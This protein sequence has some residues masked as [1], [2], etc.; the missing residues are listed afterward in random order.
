MQMPL[1]I[2]KAVQ[3]RPQ[4]EAFENGELAIPEVAKV[5]PESD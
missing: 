1:Q 4:K 3:T 2:F 5:M